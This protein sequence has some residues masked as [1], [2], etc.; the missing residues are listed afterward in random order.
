MSS[1]CASTCDRRHTSPACTVQSPRG[2]AE[3]ST[4]CSSTPLDKAWPPSRCRSRFKSSGFSRTTTGPLAS[5]RSTA[6]RTSASTP[7]SLA[8]IFSYT[9][10]DAIATA[11]STA[12]CCNSPSNWRRC[13]SSSRAASCRPATT[14]SMAARSCSCCFRPSASASTARD[15]AGAGAQLPDPTPGTSGLPESA[16]A[17]A[18]NGRLNRM[19]RSIIGSSP[20]RRPGRVAG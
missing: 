9:S 16:R 1:S 10:R 4:S 19:R 14:L 17:T 12:S 2:I 13:S 3:S 5:S 20:A 7:K 15:A 18:V 11:S 8:W 6:E